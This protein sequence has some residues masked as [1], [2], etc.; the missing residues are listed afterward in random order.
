MSN[1]WLTSDTH[2]F[3][4]NILKFDRGRP[5]FASVEDMNEFMIDRWNSVVKPGDKVYHLGDV[6]MGPGM[7]KGMNSVMNRLNGSKRLV[8]GNH[9]QVPWIANG[10]WFQKVM[11]WRNFKEHGLILT[12]LPLHAQTLDEKWEG[13]AINVHGHIHRKAAPTEKHRCVC[14]EQTGYTPV[15]IEEVRRRV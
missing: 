8:I 3:H 11:L 9:D 10:G 2:F 13:K 4:E 14:V 1:I 15:H 7:L 5:E 12:H 6:A